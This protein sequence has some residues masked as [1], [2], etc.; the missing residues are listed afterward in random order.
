MAIIRTHK[1]EQFLQIDNETI[2]N[3]ELSWEATGMLALLLSHSDHFKISIDRL[4][5]AKTN[6]GTSTKRILTELREKG[7]VHF[8]SIIKEK[9]AFSGSVWDIF[10]YPQEPDP[11]LNGKVTTKQKDNFNFHSHRMSNTEGTGIGSLDIG[12]TLED[13]SKNTKLKNTISLAKAKKEEKIK[14][15]NPLLEVFVEEWYPAVDSAIPKQFWIKAS[16]ALAEIKELEPNVTPERLREE[17]KAIRPQFTTSGPLAIS[18]HWREYTQKKLKAKEDPLEIRYKAL[19]SALITF[20]Q[21]GGEGLTVR[22][23]EICAKITDH[24]TKQDL[25]L[26]KIMVDKKQLLG[27]YNEIVS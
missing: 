19:F 4:T 5:N 7:Y 3:S 27:I 22:Q 18:G 6:G 25:Q 11:S 15:P 2:R 10:E 21:S 14:K 26:D 20:K 1:S 17:I 13:Q 9:G 16:K 12:N 24:C 8:K 23:K